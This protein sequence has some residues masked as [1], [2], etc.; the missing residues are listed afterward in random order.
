[1]APANFIW[2]SSVLFLQKTQTA[3]TFC[4]TVFYG[5]QLSDLQSWSLV[6]VVVPYITVVAL[7]LDQPY[8]FLCTFS[9]LNMCYHRSKR[10]ETNC[11]RPWRCRYTE[12]ARAWQN[13]FFLLWFPFFST[14][15]STFAFLCLSPHHYR[16]LSSHVNSTL[17][18][19]LETSFLSNSPFRASIQNWHTFMHF[20]RYI[21]RYFQK[22]ISYIPW[23]AIPVHHQDEK[24]AQLE[25]SSILPLL[26]LQYVIDS[27]TVVCSFISQGRNQ[28]SFVYGNYC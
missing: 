23:T 4:P 17:H 7:H 9:N 20:L 28:L 2:W 6:N 11:T 1:M 5:P 15:A 3:L 26:L 19:N 8:F 27:V 18:D 12:D 16:P 21:L 22:R 14:N 25:F 24:I 13:N 10:K